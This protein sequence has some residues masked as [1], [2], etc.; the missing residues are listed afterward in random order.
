MNILRKYDL[1]KIISR[2]P[3]AHELVTCSGEGVRQGP[4]ARGTLFL[5]EPHAPLTKALYMQ[6]TCRFLFKHWYGVSDKMALDYWC[7]L[8]ALPSKSEY[9]LVVGKV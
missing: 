4:E 5:K 8:A 2:G 6:Y 3:Y 7:T 9:L 1:I